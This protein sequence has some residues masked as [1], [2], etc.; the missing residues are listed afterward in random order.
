ML[1]G[2]EETRPGRARPMSRDERRAA[3]AVATIP[4]LEEHGSRV[5]TRQI[6]LAA[7]VAEGT[8]FRAFDDKVE[9]LHAAAERA[10]DPTSAVAEIDGLPDAGSLPGELR[11]V[12]DVVAARGRRIRRV[13]LAVHGI[14]ASDAGRRAA[15]VRGARG[16]DVL[17]HPVPGHAPRDPDAPEVPGPAGRSHPLHPGPIHPGAGRDARF[18]ALTEL[19]GAVV[20][21]VEPYGDELR[22]EPERLAQ[23]LL[24]AIMG[25]GPPALPEDAEVPTADLVDVLLHGAA[26]T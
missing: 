18:R 8:L 10:V 24:A 15:A 11:Q 9:L 25:Q 1:D 26:R 21:R 3:I 5:S 2:V 22:I 16:A 13:M 19:R 14:M 17:G 6:A 4:L 20:R 7:G 23:V 12:A